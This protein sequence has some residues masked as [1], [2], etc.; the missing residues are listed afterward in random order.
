MN[1]RAFALALAALVLSADAASALRQPALEKLGLIIED[2]SKPNGMKELGS[3]RR[4][5]QALRRAKHACEL[6]T[7]DYGGN[8]TC[9]TL[10][11]KR[12]Y[13]GISAVPTRSPEFASVADIRP[14]GVNSAYLPKSEFAAF[15]AD[16]VKR[17]T[18]R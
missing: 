16:L 14:D 1:S 2:G 6:S 5:M 17:P 18:T 4:F 11:G 9:T 8:I 13:I 15:M 10:S 7:Y 12:V 3:L